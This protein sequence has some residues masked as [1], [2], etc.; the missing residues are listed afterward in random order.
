M[1]IDL[2]FETSYNASLIP[3]QGSWLRILS[4]TLRDQVLLPFAQGFLWAATLIGLSWVQR[5]TRNRGFY[6]GI[7]INEWWKSLNI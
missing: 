6:W 4:I 2:R 1:L 3:A 5:T 7:M